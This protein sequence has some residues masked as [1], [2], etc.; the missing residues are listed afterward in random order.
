MARVSQQRPPAASKPRHSPP[1]PPHA[2]RYNTWR[3]PNLAVGGW[4]RSRRG[5][6]GRL[7]QGGTVDKTGTPA[8]TS[9][10]APHLFRQPHS[11][12]MFFATSLLGEWRLESSS[13]SRDGLFCFVSFFLVFNPVSTQ[14]QPSPP[15]RP[16]PPTLPPSPTTPPPIQFTTPLTSSPACALTRWPLRGPWVWATESPT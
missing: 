3:V 9:H 10:A 12:V 4:G 13:A 5:K 7:L 16:L 11:V 2:S 1:R 6:K 8:P 14:T 15:P